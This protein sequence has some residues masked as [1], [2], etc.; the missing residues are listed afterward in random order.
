M[1][2]NNLMPPVYAGRTHDDWTIS[3]A[4]PLRYQPWTWIPRHFNFF[5]FDMG[6]KLWAGNATDRFNDAQPDYPIAPDAIYGDDLIQVVDPILPPGGWAIISVYFPIIGRFPGFFTCTLNLGSRY[7]PIYF[8]FKHDITFSF[9][10]PNLTKNWG[11]WLEGS[12]SL[13]K[14]VFGASPI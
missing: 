11:Y 10:D 6:P 3:K 5:G 2:R 14:K 7:M 4:I 1:Y 8:G 9:D 12:I 13:R